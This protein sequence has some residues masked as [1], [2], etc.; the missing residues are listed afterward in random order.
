VVHRHPSTVFLCA[1][2]KEYDA[3]SASYTKETLDA[4][5][6]IVT[7]DR[8]PEYTD[9]IQSM[10]RKH[11]SICKPLE[12]LPPLRPGLYHNIPLT[13]DSFE[14]PGKTCRLSPMESNEFKKHL[15]DYLA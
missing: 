15:T 2:F 1:I 4:D 7:S 12:A 10:L 6:P 9:K 11:K 13:L 5:I 8:T 14:A 3:T